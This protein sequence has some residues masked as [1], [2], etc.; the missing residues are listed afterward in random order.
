MQIGPL[1]VV[2]QG[3]CQVERLHGL[4]VIDA[5]AVDALFGTDALP[6]DPFLLL[7][8]QRLGYLV[9]VVGGQELPFLPLKLGEFRFALGHLLG[10]QERQG[11]YLRLD[12]LPDFLALLVVQLLVGVGVLYGCLDC[13]H[14]VAALFAVAVLAT[15]A[16]EVLV[17]AALAFGAAVDQAS[18]ALAAVN[19]TA[20][21]VE[22]PPGAF[23]ADAL[24]SQ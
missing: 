18:A 11:V 23:A 16:D 9:G 2:R 21:V 19:G 22:V 8:E 6:F 5:Q 13:F 10:G 12:R 1:G 4:F 20:Q 24:G 14:A 7:G 15:P 17:L 3:E